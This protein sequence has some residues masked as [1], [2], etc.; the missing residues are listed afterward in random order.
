MIFLRSLPG[1]PEHLRVND[2]SYAHYTNF[3]RGPLS[4]YMHLTREQGL[5][6]TLKMLKELGAKDA[7]T[8]DDVREFLRQ[9]KLHYAVVTDAGAVASVR[10]QSG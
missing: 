1:L 5:A 8:D 3:T 7:P 2:T 9:Y 10:A 4:A 6:D